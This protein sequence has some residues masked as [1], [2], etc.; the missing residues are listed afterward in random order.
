MGPKRLKNKPRIPSR[1]LVTVHQTVC[2]EL[3]MYLVDYD[4]GLLNAWSDKIQRKVHTCIL[5]EFRAPAVLIWDS[6]MHRSLARVLRLNLTNTHSWWWQEICVSDRLILSY[7]DP[8]SCS[9]VVWNIMTIKQTLAEMKSVTRAQP[10]THLTHTLNLGKCLENHDLRFW[11]PHKSV[12]I[13][14]TNTRTD[15]HIPHS[16][17][18]ISERFR[19][20]FRRKHLFSI[21]SSWHEPSTGFSSPSVLR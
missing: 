4:A 8:Q 6:G 21:R 9:D 10:F 20:F 3:Y 15:F 7:E 5:F 11:A 18:V 17:L 14:S 16:P 2:T 19:P 1:R 12:Y 13:Q